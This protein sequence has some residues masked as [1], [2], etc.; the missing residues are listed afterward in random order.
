MPCW[1][2]TG[3]SSARP[4]VSCCCTK[5]P[6]KAIPPD[7]YS[8]VRTPADVGAPV[9]GAPLTLLDA[10]VHDWPRWR[11]TKVEGTWRVGPDFD[12][13]Q[14]GAGAGH[15]HARRGRHRVRR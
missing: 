5:A 15:R 8:F 6:A 14:T 7:F 9:T 4:T 10:T 13:A 12:P 11:Q 1:P 2:R 3:A